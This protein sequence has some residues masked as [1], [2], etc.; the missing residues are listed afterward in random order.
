MPP[1]VGVSSISSSGSA[2]FA[3]AFFPF[4]GAAFSAAFSFFGAFFFALG[5]AAASAAGSSAGSAAGFFFL[6]LTPAG[7]SPSYIGSTP[8][9]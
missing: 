4:A 7:P 6:G 3:A 1:P 2:F 5:S 8:T 9:P